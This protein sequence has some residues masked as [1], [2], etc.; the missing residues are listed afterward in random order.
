MTDADWKTLKRARR[1]F[2]GKAPT[3]KQL[4]QLAVEYKSLARLHRKAYDGVE[5]VQGLDE[6]DPKHVAWENRVFR[7]ERRA[8]TAK[9][10]L[11][12]AALAVKS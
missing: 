7:A 8:E 6:F 5:A 4:F 10:I 2:Q 11:L 12:A 9:E 3:A 1:R